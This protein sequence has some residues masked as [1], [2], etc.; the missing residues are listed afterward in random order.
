M[1]LFVENKICELHDV[2]Y[3]CGEFILYKSGTKTLNEVIVYL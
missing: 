2:L 1:I 3:I